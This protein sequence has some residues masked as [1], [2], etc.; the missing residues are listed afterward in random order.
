MHGNTTNIMHGARHERSDV[1]VELVYFGTVQR[2]VSCS[3]ETA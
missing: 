1:L 3:L 2:T